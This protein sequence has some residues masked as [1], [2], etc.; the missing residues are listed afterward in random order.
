[1][2]TMADFGQPVL[3]LP[4]RPAGSMP[5]RSQEAYRPMIDTEAGMAAAEYLMELLQYSPP[6]ILSMSWYERVRPYAAGKSPWPMATRCLPPI[7]S[8]TIAAMATPAICR[9]RPGRRPPGRARGRLR[10][11]HSG[12]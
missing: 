6:D 3:D 4:K 10:D 5:T 1:M 9:I 12:K 11:G 7:S 8:S 2:M